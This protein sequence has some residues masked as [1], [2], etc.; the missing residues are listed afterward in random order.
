MRW[1]PLVAVV[2]VSACQC[3]PSSFASSLFE[4][5]DEGWTLAGNGTMTRPTFEAMGGN[6]NGHIC[7]TDANQDAETLYF[8]APAKYYGN[9]SQLFGTRFIFDLKINRTF[10]LIRGEDVKLNGG[11]LALVQNFNSFPG[12][13]WTPRLGSVRLDGNSNWKVEET[14]AP[15]T[16]DDMRAVL[17]NLTSI[18]IRGDFAD[19]SGDITCLDNVYFGTP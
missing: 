7:G 8:V 11:G 2:F 17:R 5:D 3:G 6:A 19:G 13:D 14:G 15:A 1:V 10:A 18:R 12:S 16:E 4:G 9:A